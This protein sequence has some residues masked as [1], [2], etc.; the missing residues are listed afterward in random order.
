MNI[1]IALGL[2]SIAPVASA[3]N[4]QDRILLWDKVE[5]GMTEP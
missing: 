4:A 5:A 2:V 3:A 1:T